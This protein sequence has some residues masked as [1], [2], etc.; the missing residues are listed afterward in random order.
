MSELYFENFFRPKIPSETPLEVIEKT[1]PIQ[2]NEELSFQIPRLMRIIREEVGRLHGE[3]PPFPL[4]LKKI[5]ESL[6]SLNN[7]NTIQ[8]LEELEELLDIFEK[9]EIK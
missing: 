7:L 4:I 1:T 8:L 9:K 5:E 3:A 2:L 6:A